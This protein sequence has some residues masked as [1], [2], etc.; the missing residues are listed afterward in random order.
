MSM[1]LASA[2]EDTSPAFSADG[3][4]LAYT[5]LT[6]SKNYLFVRRMGASGQPPGEPTLVM[7]GAKGPAGVHSPIWE[8]GGK[9][10]LFAYGSQLLEWEHGGKTRVLYVA[11]EMLQ[12]VTASWDA[13]LLPRIIYS[14]GGTQSATQLRV[15][16]LADGGRRAE[17]PAVPL[18]SF[19]GSQ[20]R[21]D[22]SPDGRWIAFGS[23]A[24]GAGEIWLAASDGK[25]ARQ[26]T[27]L[28]A[29]VANAPRWS[30]DGKQIA[31][32]ARLPFIAQPYVLHLDPQGHVAPGTVPR[33]VT[34]TDNGMCCPWWS[35]D[36]KQLYGIGPMNKPGLPV[37]AY[38]IVRL[39]VAGGKVEDLFQGDSPAISRDYRQVFYGNPLP[40]PGL[41]AR[42]LLGDVKSNPEKLIVEDYVGPD[43]FAPAGNGIF[44]VGRDANGRAEAIRFF[45]F[46][47]RRTFD[48]GPAPIAAII[49]MTVSPDGRKLV[50]DA[51]SAAHDDLISVQFRRGSN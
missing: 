23:R 7:A 49:G 30:P 51:P 44:Y 41:F 28:N 19:N 5:A 42:S 8:P 38:R 50:Y 9:R 29:A 10:L 6:P 37:D 43:G 31:F 45:N 18:L 1:L 22:F 11:P 2:N 3:Q 36:G 24:S 39:T 35:G 21:S 47:L 16:S 14:T 26:L 17:G 48:L 12:R 13:S 25:N 34:H 40:G 15:L 4:W 33:Q 20:F 46:R 27:H 32:F